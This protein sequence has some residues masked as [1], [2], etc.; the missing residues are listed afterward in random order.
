MEEENILAEY[1]ILKRLSG[2]DYL[3]DCK[4]VKR[5]AVLTLG[6]WFCTAR[7][8]FDVWTAHCPALDGG[9]RTVDA[10]ITQSPVMTV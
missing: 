3:S 7:A 6:V 2:N 5:H 8:V 9:A 4:G 10:T 1:T